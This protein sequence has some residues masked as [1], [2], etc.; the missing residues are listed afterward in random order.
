MGITEGFCGVNSIYGSG[1]EVQSS[2]TSHEGSNQAQKK[3]VGN[4]KRLKDSQ[5][6]ATYTSKKKSNQVDL[7]YH[8]R[9]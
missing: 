3:R 4:R 2:Q 7:G 1:N 9:D 5:T 6:I 8:P